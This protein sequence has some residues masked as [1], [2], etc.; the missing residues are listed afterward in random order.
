MCVDCVMNRFTKPP[1][2]SGS[3]KREERLEDFLVMVCVC[4]LRRLVR[5]T[6]VYRGVES[7]KYTVE[8]G[9]TIDG[10]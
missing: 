4:T 8:D 1:S 10:L 5:R 2:G 9:G 3:G 7:M 6:R